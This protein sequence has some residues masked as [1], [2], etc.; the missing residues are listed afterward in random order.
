MFD[1]IIKDKANEHTAPVPPDAWDNI[2]HKKKKRRAAFWWWS[3]ALLL[4]LVATTGGYLLLKNEKNNTVARIKEKDNSTTAQKTTAAQSQENEIKTGNQVQPTLPLD[5]NADITTGGNNT[6][7]PGENI[8]KYP[9]VVMAGT[10]KTT[11]TTAAP[12]VDENKPMPAAQNN[13]SKKIK[14]KLTMQPTIPGIDETLAAN[15]NIQTIFDKP[16]AEQQK[17]RD[18]NIRSTIT[19]ETGE[20]VTTTEEEKKE[21]QTNNKTEKAEQAKKENTL[22]AKQK[23]KKHWFIEAAAI[24]L[25]AAAQYNKNIPFNR[26]VIANNSVSVYRANLVTASI[27]PAVAISL[28]LR[29]QASKKISIG[30][31]LQYM[32]LKEGISITGKETTTSFTVVNRLAN[33]QLLADTV[34]TTTEG[35]RSI[36]AVNSYQLFSIPVFVQYNIIQK[37]QWSAAAVGGFYFNIS[38]NYKNEINRNAAAALLPAPG[39]TNK[40]NTGLDLFAGIRM[41]KRLSKR[42]DVF[43]MPSIRLSLA[44]YNIKSSLLDKNINQAGVGFGM[45]YKV[46]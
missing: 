29:R 35:T 28:L 22:A 12:S 6:T 43:A 16:A 8:N 13:K 3:S 30:T 42:L 10:S 46:N 11:I 36:K 37:Q 20:E 25:L 41:S 17:E 7:V 14:D 31:G 1:D 4:L 34:T 19:T 45:C 18:E 2:I 9:T 27:E 26:T 21:I 5:D 15:E 39:T 24:P 44:K 23:I 32:L 40:T 33:G 38:S